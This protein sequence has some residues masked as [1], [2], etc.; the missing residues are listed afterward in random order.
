MKRAIE[1]YKENILIGGDSN[2]KDIDW[3]TC[4]TNI[5]NVYN[6]KNVLLDT[7]TYSKQ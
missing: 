4:G 6:V 3:E 7:V 2:C 5:R 1:R